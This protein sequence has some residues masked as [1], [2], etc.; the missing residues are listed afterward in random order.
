MIARHADGV[1]LSR[2]AEGLN[3][4]LPAISLPETLNMEGIEAVRD[5]RLQLYIRAGVE[6]DEFLI[7]LVIPNGE[8]GSA[9][10]FI[11][12]AGKLLQS[13]PDTYLRFMLVA[14]GGTYKE[15]QQFEREVRQMTYRE[16][17]EDDFLLET[18]CDDPL[19]LIG[20]FDLLVLPPSRMDPMDWLARP[21]P[22]VSR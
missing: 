10:V 4:S 11:R 12:A 9:G 19:V 18:Q 16:G 2:G 6:G 21:W 1:I 22:A 8:T 17:I 20:G 3:K 7:G 15:S 14:L 5:Q 13:L